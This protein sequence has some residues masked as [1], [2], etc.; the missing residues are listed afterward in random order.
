MLSRSSLT[1]YDSADPFKRKERGRILLKD[2]RLVERV[3]M[4]QNIL[5]ASFTNASIKLECLS[6]S[7]L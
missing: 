4:L 2:V 5:H 6:R 7:L 1:Y 3:S